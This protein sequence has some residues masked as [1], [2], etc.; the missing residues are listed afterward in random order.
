MRLVSVVGGIVLL[1]VVALLTPSLLQAGERGIA[2]EWRIALPAVGEKA[3]AAE[4]EGLHHRLFEPLARR[5][6]LG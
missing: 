3:Q 2:G 5:P 6:R 1:V 4:R